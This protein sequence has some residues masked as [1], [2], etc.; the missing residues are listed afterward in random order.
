MQAVPCEGGAGLSVSEVAEARCEDWQT[1]SLSGGLLLAVLS[2]D[3]DR[4]A[5]SLGAM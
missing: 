4:R 2:S 1:S 3:L 5:H